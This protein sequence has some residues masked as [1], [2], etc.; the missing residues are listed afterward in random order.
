MFL[1]ILL[2][3]QTTDLHAQQLFFKEPAT[4]WIEAVPLGNGRIG[5]MHYGGIEEDILKLNADT[6]WSGP[7]K[8]GTNPEAKNILP[9]IRKALFEGRWN[10]VD[11]LAQKMQGPFSEAFMPLGDLIIKQQ[12]TSPNLQTYTR[13]LNL[14]NA[15]STVEIPTATGG[16]SREVFV[17]HPA[18][19]LVVRIT[20]QKGKDINLEVGLTTQLRSS[21]R[22]SPHYRLIMSGRGPYHSPR[23]VT[24]NKPVLF[25]D[26]P[27]GE[28]VRYATALEVR[29]EDGK[30]VNNAESISVSNASSV[31]LL[32]STATSFKTPIEPPGKDENAVIATANKTLDALKNK[33][34][35]ALKQEHI[36][37]Y[38]KLYNRVQLNL[39]GNPKTAE[40]P[41]PQRI[42]NF[43]EDQDPGLAELVFN[44]GRYLLIS[45]SRP[46]SR[47][48]NLQGIW[49]DNI[50]PPWNSNYTVNINTEMNYWPAEVTNLAECHEPL[51]ELVKYLSITGRKTAEVNYGMPGWVA[52]HNVDVWAKSTPVGLGSGDPV[53]ANWP[54]GGAWLATHLYDSYEFSGDEQFLRK[55][56]PVLKGAAEF[57]LAWLVEDQ[58]PNAPRMVDGRP[59]LV[60]APS[61]SPE[62][63]F[64]DPERKRRATGIGATMDIQIIRRLFAAILDASQKL[65]IDSE[66]AFKVREAKSRLLPNQIGSRGQLMEWADDFMETEPTHRHLSHLYGVYPSNEITPEST[67]T[68]TK[69]VRK[70]LDIRGDE[71]TGW[72]MGWRLCIWARLLDPDRAYGMMNYLM[73][74]ADKQD[75]N[76][77]G[78]GGIYPNLFDAHPPFQIDGNFAFT[79]GVAEM[80]LQSHEG[81]IVLL[82]TLPKQWPNG[83]VKG[84]R[85]RGGFTVDIVWE[86]HEVKSAKI[87]ATKS[88]S[89]YLKTTKPVQISSKGKRIP[90]QNLENEVVFEAKAQ[91]SYEITPLA[92]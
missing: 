86:N 46:G 54:L 5:A 10:E 28:G 39:N 70:T 87:H 20:S 44:F 36:N 3:S 15:I 31:T 57:C 22:I 77:K 24:D 4:R 85:A 55:W 76:Y 7:P 41:T 63:G 91:E 69:V 38:Q 23:T 67:P 45:C 48:A 6:L 66:F 84:L 74:L 62:L 83:S 92:P 80:L 14:S 27:N 64:F 58:R 21:Y 29:T 53:W 1:T 32:L 9:E 79:A 30:V 88:G 34:Y 68:L 18:K 81:R 16:F 60:T 89:C 47:V 42:I 61:V 37:D 2:A 78:G 33:T 59:Y 12:V 26:S 11:T 19:A 72:G 73:R 51:F 75:P 8:D 65:E 56:Y 71:A 40:I 13:T 82:P 50:R 35:E 49:N 52:H 25:D 43:R 90:F 17:S